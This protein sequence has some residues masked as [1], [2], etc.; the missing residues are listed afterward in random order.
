M[1]QIKGRVLNAAPK[2]P[3]PQPNIKDVLNTLTPEELAAVQR[4]ALLRQYAYVEGGPEEDAD[5][6]PHAPPKGDSAR[7]AEEKKAAEERKALI[8]AA[9][10]LDGKKKKYKKQQ[11][12]GYLSSFFSPWTRSSSAWLR[13]TRRPS[14]PLAR[15]ATTVPGLGAGN[16]K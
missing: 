7:S 11:E 1:L 8:A 12:G 3:S 15:S 2:S 9:V 10:K 14:G 16:A 5:R 13:C 4:Q 6:D